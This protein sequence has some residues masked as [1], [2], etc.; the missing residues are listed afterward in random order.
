MNQLIF[1]HHL[2]FDTYMPRD[3][4]PTEKLS[5]ARESRIQIYLVGN[6]RLN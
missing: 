6:T 1:A 5:G 2:I 3:T 4:Y